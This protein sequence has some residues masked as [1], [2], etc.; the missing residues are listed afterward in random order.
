MLPAS[1][2]TYPLLLL[3]SVYKRRLTRSSVPQRLVV[4]RDMLCVVVQ[5]KGMLRIDD[6]LYDAAPHHA[7]F[8]RPSMELEAM[9]E[10][11]SAEYYL[12][13]LN[14]IEIARNKREWRCA[15]TGSDRIPLPPGKLPLAHGEPLG[16]EIRQLYQD[17][18][19]KAIGAFE[20][21]VRFQSILRFI[22]QHL[23]VRREAEGA[24]KG[25]DQSIGYMLKHY[26]EKIK[27]TALSEIAGLTQT[28]YSR[29]FKKAKGVTPVE[30]LNGI[31]IDSSKRLLQEPSRSIKEV[32][33]TVGFGNE[34]YFSRMFK[35]A[36]GISPVMYARR[37][38]LKVA[39]ASCFRYEQNLRC[40]GLEPHA[41]MNAF[42]LG[43]SEE[44]RRKR[45]QEQLKRMR[46]AQPD[47]I[48]VDRRHLP[49]YEQLKQI[50]PTVVLEY[51]MDWR[52]NHIRIA[53]LTGREK[54]AQQNIMQVEQKVQYAQRALAQAIGSE[55]VS[56]LRPIGRTIRIQGFADHPLNELLYG[57]LGLNP[58]SIVP[59]HQRFKDFAVGD[60]PPFESDRL[61]IYASA[62][63]AG[64]EALSSVQGSADWHT[65][66]A[67]QTR[68]VRVVYDW[69]GL[70]WSPAGQKQIIDELLQWN[71]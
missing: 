56:F 17:S 69:I 3:T 38:Q 42:V 57:G 16:E 55:T 46:E 13:L 24:S 28:S 71:A 11:S 50:A 68:H 67:V 59:L 29:S 5:G 9:L 31:R 41:A 15:E 37:R 43:Q 63:Q 70:S 60:L 14:P 39:T 7:F 21:Q 27:L 8:L 30:Y 36:I 33:D 53:E 40:L 45:V 12:L 51:T 32:A 6:E 2:D 48:L 1:D 10:S 61:L 54:E 64:S 35:R 22:L 20:R 47:L 49:F 44:D 26:H 62:S 25:I 58:G 4:P 18:R 52:K 23:T 34:F 65:M 66:P 19:S